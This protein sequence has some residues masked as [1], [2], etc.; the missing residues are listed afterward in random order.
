MLTRSCTL[1]GT[2]SPEV[3]QK[4]TAHI[5]DSSTSAASFAN[6]ALSA[7]VLLTWQGCSYFLLYNQLAAT[8]QRLKLQHYYLDQA[9]K[10]RSHSTQSHLTMRTTSLAIALTVKR[11]S[12]GQSRHNMTPLFVHTSATHHP[13]Q[14]HTGIQGKHVVN[15]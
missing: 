2:C 15:C 8:H 6:V 13:F 5:A 1:S 4:S 9:F 7:H 11:P 12:K 3:T 14:G 10:Y